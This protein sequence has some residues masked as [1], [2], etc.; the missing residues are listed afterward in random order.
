MWSSISGGMEIS[1]FR[2]SG[3]RTAI[4]AV[5]VFGM[6]AGAGAAQDEAALI[7]RSVLFGNPDRVAPQL[8]R[9]GSRLAF[10]A[11]VDGVLNVWVGPSADPSA[12]RAVTKETKRGIRTYFWAPTGEHILYRQDSD[13]DEN[14][15][16]YCVDL[17]EGE[18]RDLTP[19]DD[20]Q[21]RVQEVSHDFPDEILVAANNRI[22]QMHDLHRVNIRTGEMTLVAENTAGFLGFLT[23]S[24]FNV[25]FAL[26][27]TPDGG[28]EIVEPDG[29][30]WKLYDRIPGDDAL[31]TSPIGFTRDGRTLYMTDSRDRNTAAIYAVDLETGERS[32]LAEDARCDAVGTLMHPRERRVQ[33]VGFRYD[34]LRWEILDPEIEKDFA[35]LATVAEGDFSVV[36]RTYDDAHWIVAYSMDRGP[37]RYYRYDRSAGRAEF[38]FTSSSALESAPLARMHPVFPK[39]RDGLTL[40]S[41][42]TL[43]PAAD[44]DGDG[45]PDRA[46]PMVLLVHGGPWARD[47]WGYNPLHQ[48]LANRGYAVLS[49]NFRGSTGFG[50]QFVNAGDREWA[51]KM[52]DDLI[53]AVDWAVRERIADADRVAI[54]GGSYG[55]YATLVGL[56]FT[57]DKF[58]CGV[59]IVG[60]SN[61]VTLLE[62]IPPYWK[63]MVDM[64]VR[65]IGDHRTEEGREFLMSRS[66]LS[67]A[68][69]IRRPLLIGQG[70]NDPRVK[71]AESDQIVT[72]MNAHNIPVTYALYPD[73][74]HGFARPEN[75]MSFYAVAESFLAKHLGGAAEP[76]GKDFEGANIQVPAGAD[77]IPGLAEALKAMNP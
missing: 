25:R 48:W 5:L 14:W 53:D 19:F 23:D 64:F 34:R 66:P 60:P 12:A 8:N 40:V 51:A 46:L 67:R 56:T 20:A 61:L 30:G 42:L 45:R 21:A 77:H 26:R 68:D 47:D 54:M 52:H 75:R 76:I 27:M 65:R 24:R 35:Y 43:P 15:R 70:A 33:A 38:L 9:D 39:S 69:E 49:V 41:Y 31:T 3:A 57:P 73:E 10:L 4:V 50:K 29:D 59:D 11:P 1:S 2:R 71:Q 7:P 36:N 55:G 16:I 63:P 72:A 17:A 58:A 37:T 18:I 74:G 32:L 28:Q 13:G 44:P 6:T 62:S 22:P